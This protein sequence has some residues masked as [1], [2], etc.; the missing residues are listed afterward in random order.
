MREKYA[1]IL[2]MDLE[3]KIER[4][5]FP[6]AFSICDRIEQEGKKELEMR[7]TQ[8]ISTN[9]PLRRCAILEG[10]TSKCPIPLC[11]IAEGPSWE[12]FLLPEIG[13]VYSM[14]MDTYIESINIPENPDEGIT[15]REKPLNAM[16]RS[17]KNKDTQNVI[18]EAFDKSNIVK[19]R[20][21]LIRDILWA[22]NEGKYTLS[23]PLLII[24]IEGIL[25][26]LAYLFK[27]KFK[28]EEMYGGE[29]ARV[30]AIIKKLG[31][32]AFDNTLINFYV[33]KNDSEN[34]PRNLILH[35][36]SVDYGKDYRLSTVLFLILIY[37]ITFSQMK[38]QGRITLE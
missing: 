38:I 13:A 28:K 17:L 22:H 14:L 4:E 30:W 5:L 31:D 3:N 18:I 29:S 10:K 27:W 12:D 6:A 11:W 33:R 32:K 35:G 9:C 34:S 37:L 7:L 26:D 20:T 8:Y 15:F 23:V 2:I 24:Q 16:N 19:A 21:F 36:R 25:H 1:T